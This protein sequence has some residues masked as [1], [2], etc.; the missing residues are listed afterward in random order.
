VKKILSIL[1][2][3]LVGL[4]AAQA[5]SIDYALWDTNQL[6]S[7]QQCAAD[8]TAQTGIEV[9]VEQLGW[10]DYWSFVQTGF[11][12]GEAP[13]VFTNHLA[14]YPEFVSLGQ[15][16]D[17]QPLVERDGVATDIYYA[18]LA[19]LWTRDGG[20]YGLPKDWDTIAIVYNADALEAAG[21]TV[22]EL[23]NATWNPE[24]GGTFEEIIARLTI[25]ENGNNGL[26]P[27]FDADAVVQY[28]FITDFGGAGAYGQTQWSWLT[29][30]LGWDF[31]NGTWGD[32]YYYDDP[33]FAATIQWMA[34]LMIEKGY[35]PSL[36]D[37]S[38]LGHAAIFQSGTAALVSDGSWMIGTY[39]GSE[40]DVGFARLPIGP[41][42]RRSMFNGLADSIWVGT[43][44]LESSW[45]W[46]KYLGS[47]ACQT[48]VG[49]SGVVFPAIPSAAD[50]SLQVRAENGVDVSAFTEQAAEENGTF[51]FPI[52]D[53]GSEINTIMSEAIQAVGLGQISAE[54]AFAEV[55]E[56]I[57]DLF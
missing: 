33:R 8:F 6:P 26:S 2:T 47:E 32:E 10:G 48:I 11:V 46:V 23:N 29:H 3:A 42:G 12:S 51:L 20:R 19:E 35:M 27:D 57:N 31:N 21:V 22:D 25:D 36:E 54:E 37:Q 55:N 38:S 30:T 39:L 45:E 50:L 13:D 40:F 9:N 17:L 43:D 15:L 7:Y 44:D 24:D 49:R 28:G 56:E 4:G 16:V 18:G 52:T 5:Q 14:R 34:D 41:E 53:Y 1:I